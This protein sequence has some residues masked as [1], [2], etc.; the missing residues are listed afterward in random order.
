MADVELK[1]KGIVL[2]LSDVL[3]DLNAAADTETEIFEND[4]VDPYEVDVF[5][6]AVLLYDFS[7]ACTTAVVK[8][9]KTGGSCDEFLGDTTLSNVSGTSSFLWCMPVPSSTPAECIKIANGES[10]GV[11]ITTPEGS[12]LTCKAALFAT[13]KEA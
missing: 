13:M 5:T 9:G 6:F 2:F 1:E 10:F 11:K 12:A 3:V 7:A 8:F 4:I